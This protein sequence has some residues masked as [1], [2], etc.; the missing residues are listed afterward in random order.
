MEE[1]ELAGTCQEDLEMLRDALGLPN[2]TATITKYSST[3]VCLNCTPAYY[4]PKNKLRLGAAGSSVQD[5]LDNMHAAI[6]G[7][8]KEGLL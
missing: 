5:C 6:C 4:P 7:W 2:L 1:F 8:K 3:L